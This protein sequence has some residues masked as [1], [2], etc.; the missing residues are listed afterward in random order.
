MISE[1]SLDEEVPLTIDESV[2]ND[3]DDDDEDEEASISEPSPIK[4]Q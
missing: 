1:E 2:G 4:Q 3:D